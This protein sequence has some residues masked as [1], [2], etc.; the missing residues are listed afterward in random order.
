MF[1]DRAFFLETDYKVY[2]QARQL[3]V[4]GTSGHIANYTYGSSDF[5]VFIILFVV[6]SV[7]MLR[8]VVGC[9]NDSMRAPACYALQH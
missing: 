5:L 2:L 7:L 3:E 4:H 8:P 1:D 6:R 9:Q